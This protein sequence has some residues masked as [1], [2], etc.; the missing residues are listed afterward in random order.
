[1]SDGERDPEAAAHLEAILENIPL[2]VFVKDA[3]TLSFVR[4]NRA[5]EDLL[6]MRREDLIGRGDRDVFP[7]EQAEFFIAKDREVL[8]KGEVLDTPEEPIDTPSGRRWL[9]TRKLPLRD[10]FGEPRYLLGISEDV[11]ERVHARERQDVVL[12]AVLDGV[13]MIDERGAVSFF[14]AAAEAIFGYPRS[15]V[16]GQ[17][18]RMLMPEPYRS[19]HDGY[20]ENYRRTRTPRVIGIGREVVGRRKDGGH[21]P[22]ELSVTEIVGA[23][24][25]TTYLG[26]VRD[27]TERVRTDTALRDSQASLAHAQEIAHVGSWEWDIIANAIGWSDEAYRIFGLVPGE[28]DP[29]YEAFL[30]R[31]HP[32]DRERVM[33]AVRAAMEDDAPYGLQHRVVRPDGGERVAYEQ[34]EVIRDA[35]GAPIRFVGVVHDIT[36][37]AAVESMLAQFRETLDQTRDSVFIFDANTLFFTYANQGAVDQVGWSAEEL[38]RMHPYD[39]KPEFTPES[40]RELLVPLITGPTPSLVVQTMH[41]HRDGHLIPVEIVLQYVVSRGDDARFVAIVRDITERRRTEEALRRSN[42]DLE[43]FASLASHDLQAPL[44]AVSGFVDI[45]R[46][47]LG[48]AIDDEGRRYM[49][50]I[51]DG[52]QRMRALVYGILAYSRVDHDGREMAT[53]RLGDVVDRV[54]ADLAPMIDSARARLDVGPLPEVRGDA[55]Q[56]GALMQNL[57]ENAVKYQTEGTTPEVTIRA[58][59][60]VDGGHRITIA[61]NGIGIAPADRERVFEMFQRLHGRDRYAGTG[62]GLALCR[63]IVERHGGTIAIDDSPAGGTTFVVFLPGDPQALR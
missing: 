9:R 24:G 53:V 50:H 55:A 27:V 36:E 28:V 15:E 31:V 37:R 1:M 62:L 29:T 26:T 12:E 7:P 47:H 8:A 54:R 63:R 46:D 52:V 51:L 10:A 25:T 23:D 61:D 21:F 39:I 41:R 56:L 2:M 13:I 60:T 43:R 42:A 33:E 57:V 6:G 3:E 48:D 38:M 59:A 49:N 22:M 44:R 5:G 35:D 32:D 58:T 4:I 16:V 20:L 45:L 18:V 17:N 40:F 30:E 14:S 11:T 19:E 34:G